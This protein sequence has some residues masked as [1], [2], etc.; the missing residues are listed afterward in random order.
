[1]FRSDVFISTFTDDALV[2]EDHLNYAGKQLIQTC[3][4]SPDPG[5]VTPTGNAAHDDQRMSAQ[6]FEEPE[7]SYAPP[8]DSKVLHFLRVRWRFLFFCRS[9]R[10]VSD[11][12]TTLH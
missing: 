5:E 6:G 2:T 4:N 8:E 3:L 1:V 12:F 7:L 10:F 9:V 11:H